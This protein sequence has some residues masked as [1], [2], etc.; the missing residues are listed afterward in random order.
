[1]IAKKFPVG[2]PKFALTATISYRVDTPAQRYYSLDSGVSIDMED[3]PGL[4]RDLETF[5]THMKAAQGKAGENV[6]FRYSDKFWVSFFSFQDDRGRPQQILYFNPGRFESQGEGT[7]KTLG[8]YIDA[9]KAGQTKL[10]EL[11]AQR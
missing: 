4:I 1:M 10:R 8:S 7:E 11:Q 6:Y 5:V 3:L 2:D 9:L